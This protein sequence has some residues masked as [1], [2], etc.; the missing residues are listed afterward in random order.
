[1]CKYY[2]RQ[3]QQLQNSNRHRHKECL[4]RGQRLNTRDLRPNIRYHSNGCWRRFR[5]SFRLES[6]RVLRIAMNQLMSLR[7]LHCH[8]LNTQ[9]TIGTSSS[10]S[11]SSTSRSSITSRSGSTS[12][13]L[14][15]NS[16]VSSSV[17]FI[18]LRSNSSISSGRS[19]RS[20]R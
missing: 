3:P 6:L 12:R 13:S 14:W 16:S 8:R 2:D 17:A 10:G 11:S 1:M 5:L 15:S 20:G 7:T 9:S 19:G 18:S 4:C